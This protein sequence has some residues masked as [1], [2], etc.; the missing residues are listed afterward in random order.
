MFVNP[1]VFYEG[2][3]DMKKM[4][5]KIANEEQSGFRVPLKW[6]SRKTN[7]QGAPE[8]ERLPQS[9]EQEYPLALGF[10][11]AGKSY[12]CIS[13]LQAAKTEQEDVF[14]DIYGR[15]VFCARERFPCFDS[16]DYLYEHRYYRWFYLIVNDKLTQVYY[17]DERKEIRVTED[18]AIIRGEH[19]EDMRKAGFLDE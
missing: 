19:F 11:A 7:A 15:K 6:V 17:E 16:Y 12:S 2:G 8:T 10:R 13:Q 1:V 3:T 14:L 4:L 5:L 9:A 18:A